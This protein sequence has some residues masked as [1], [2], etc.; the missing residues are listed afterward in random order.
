MT[1]QILVEPF[2]AIVLVGTIRV[3]WV[4]RIAFDIV[5]F[6]GEPGGVVSKMNEG[7]LVPVTRAL[8][9]GERKDI[10]D[11]LVEIDSPVVDELGKHRAGKGFRDGTYL[12]DAVAVLDIYQRVIAS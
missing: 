10:P 5:R 4:L 1:G 8:I 12:K 11:R 6:E 2:H 3:K 9:Q 7:D